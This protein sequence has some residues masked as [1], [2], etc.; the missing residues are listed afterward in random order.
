MPEDDTGHDPFPFHK[1]D[2]PTKLLI[3]TFVAL[4]FLAT[5][6]AIVA[7][8]F[9]RGPT[10]LDIGLLIGMAT[11]TGLGLSV[12]YH[13]MLTHHA[14]H[15]RMPTRLLLLI[16]GSMTMEGPPADWAATHTRH[17]SRSD[18]EGDPHSPQDGF[19]HAHFL[20][21]F[22]DR[23]VRSGPAHDKLMEDRVVHFV[24]KTW[25]FW[26]II[27][28]LIPAAIGLGVTGTLTGAARGLVW[29]GLVRVFV[30]HHLTWSVN[31]ISHLFGARPY[32][33]RDRSANNWFVGLFAWGEGWHNNH[34]AFPRAAYMGM[35]WWQF[36]LGAWLIILL[37]GLGQIRHVVQPSRE[38]K[39]A[40]Q[41]HA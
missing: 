38:E 31:S 35:R 19:W 39:A 25:V 18:R 23:F 26:A 29:G 9:G 2:W 36:D 17:H 12:G 22:R 21:M 14:F 10:L 28:V 5:L 37:R 8:F 3:G 13:R 34:H 6:A 11:V 7:L 24:T 4:P 32:H 16:F 1:D 41:G 30:V 20:W 27:G 40:R 33:N 15:A